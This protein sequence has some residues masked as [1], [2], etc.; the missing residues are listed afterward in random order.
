MYVLA[1]VPIASN[2]TVR[3]QL[4]EHLKDVPDNPSYDDIKGVP[5]LRNCITETLR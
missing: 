1:V 2:H 4:L 5:Y 3:L